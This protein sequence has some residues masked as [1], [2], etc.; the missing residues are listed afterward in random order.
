MFQ[1]GIAAE[2]I[3]QAATLMRS[4]PDNIPNLSI[5]SFNLNGRS[6]TIMRTN[7]SPT[8][9]IATSSQTNRDSVNNANLVIGLVIGLVAAVLVSLGVVVGIRKYRRLKKKEI[10]ERENR[11]LNGVPDAPEQESSI[12]PRIAFGTFQLKPL[13]EAYT[14]RWARS[15]SYLAD[16]PSESLPTLDLRISNLDDIGRISSE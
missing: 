5:V 11:L 1:V 14:S 9:A 2:N 12:I 7:Q 8:V 6:S 16:P 15:S 10:L 4:N 3:S 13:A